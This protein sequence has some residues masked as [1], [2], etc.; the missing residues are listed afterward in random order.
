MRAAAATLRPGGR[1]VAIT[2]SGCVPGEGAW[3]A[4]L[5]PLTPAVRTVFTMAVD[6]RAYA[7]RGTVFDVRL[8][9]LERD[10]AGTAPAVALD[11]GAR[12]DSPAALLDALKRTLPARRPPGPPA[13]ER[14][15]TLDL[16]SA[17]APKRRRAPKPA[18]APQREE[19]RPA[20]EEDAHLG[21]CA[22]LAY[23]TLAASDASEPETADGPYT[24]WRA[25]AVCVG[26]ARPHPTALVQSSAMAAVAHPSPSYRPLLPERV[27]ADGLLSDAQLESVVLAGEAHETHLG[28]RVRIGEGLETVLRAGADGAAVE[29]AHDRAEAL[30]APVRLRRGWMLG[31]GTGT[32]KG[33]GRSP[34]SSST[35]GSGAGAAPCGS[36]SRR[37]SSRTP[38]ATGRRSADGERTSSR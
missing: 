27:V 17:P 29:D 12:A 13:V 24:P 19:T 16:F 14:G 7:R 20:R 38:G 23:A 11:P 33:A 37:S 21:P 18:D 32:G 31:D 34:A 22:E 4:A 30:S 15:L 9:V 35:T 36:A 5:A 1:L 10:G 26:G 3:P 8:T 28:V 25:G 6:G 2:S